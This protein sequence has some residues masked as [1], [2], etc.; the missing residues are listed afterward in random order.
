MKLYA[1]NPGRRVRQLFADVLALVWV[2]ACVRVGMLIHSLVEML[3]VPGERIERAGDGF[4]RTVE[5]LGTGLEDLPLV[6][7]ELRT[8]FEIVAEAGDALQRAGQAQ[9]DVV[10]AL[11]LWLAVL[12]A[13]IPIAVVLLHYLPD[14]WRWIREASAASQIR[15]D[16]ADLELFALRAVVNRPLHELREVSPDPAGALSSGDYGALAKLEL[17]ALGLRA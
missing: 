9:Q 8:P 1:E 10:H 2:V 6:G 15:V 12:I 16:A 7:D 17:R 14:R 5:S 3:A 13:V 4:S 11:A